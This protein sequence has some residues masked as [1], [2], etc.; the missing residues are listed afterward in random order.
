MLQLK[1]KFLEEDKEIEENQDM[2]DPFFENVSEKNEAPQITEQ[3]SEVIEK[4]RRICR[5]FR[6][7]PLKNDRLQDFVKNVFNEELKFI[8]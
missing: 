7:Y 1:M 6:N 8:L 2:T 3:Y 4:V 5:M